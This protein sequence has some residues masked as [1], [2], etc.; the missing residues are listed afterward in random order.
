MV[1][2]SKGALDFEVEKFDQNDWLLNV[3]NGTV[4]LRTGEMHE[5]S[6]HDFITKLAP[7]DYI[8][9]KRSDLW[10]KTLLKIFNG[11]EALVDYFQ[12]AIGYALTGDMSEK[13]MFIPYGSGNNG[14]SL[15]FGI[16]Q[17]ALGDYSRTANTELILRQPGVPKKP[18][19]MAMIVGARL[20][21]IAELGTGKYL[22]ESLVK[23][24]TGGDKLTAE[25]KYKDP[26]DFWPQT[27]LFA[28]TNFL[29]RIEDFT[30][31]NWN[32]IKVIPF[33]VTFHDCTGA[34]IDPCQDRDLTSA[35]KSEAEG[36][37]AWAIEGTP[38]WLEQG[39]AEPQSV[40]DATESYKQE[41][42]VLSM[43]VESECDLGLG[44]SVKAKP[45][46]EAYIRWLD[47]DARAEALSNTAFGKEMSK[48]FKKTTVHGAN[49]YR[50]IALKTDKTDVLLKQALPQG[51]RLPD[52]EYDD[53][54]PDE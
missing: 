13:A 51:V 14:K 3:A 2:L 16:L 15:V 20:V 46:Y 49:V 26:I 29:P 38:K 52:D 10:E 24:L 45:L 23:P 31:E 53:L 30:E 43:F 11:D 48:R 27:T 42:N 19:D 17:R 1:D 35:L 44:L 34:V 18:Y 25:Q 22:D 7:V 50:G 28:Y 6:P 36:I 33:N 4:D 54:D 9:G 37:L 5:H 21:I 41:E 47:P 12:R 40:R 8:K 32:R 39:L